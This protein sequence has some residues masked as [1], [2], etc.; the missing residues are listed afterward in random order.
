MITPP[1][2]AI[3]RDRMYRVDSRI[4]FDSPEGAAAMLMHVVAIVAPDT[5]G[6][7]SGTRRY[8]HRNP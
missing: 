1:L 6:Y 7:H 4:K 8:I 5:S 2:P 3:M